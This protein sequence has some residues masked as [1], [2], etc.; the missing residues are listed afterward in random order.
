[1]GIKYKNVNEDMSI[2]EID[3][4]IKMREKLMRQM[5][6]N[7]YPAILADEIVKLLEKKKIKIALDHLK[8]DVI[9]KT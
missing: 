4:Q 3:A 6:G 8:Y 5:V 1:M 7:L 2:V 9:S